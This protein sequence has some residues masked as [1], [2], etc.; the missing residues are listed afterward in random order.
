M[1]DLAG[2]I[3]GR[4]VRVPVLFIHEFADSALGGVRGC[5]LGETGVAY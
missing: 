3:F 2:N 4:A 5:Y 1:S